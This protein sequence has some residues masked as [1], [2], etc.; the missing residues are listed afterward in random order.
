MV[1]IHRKRIHGYKESGNMYRTT[2]CGL[3][4][5]LAFSESE[6]HHVTLG[7]HRQ[8]QMPDVVDFSP[9]MSY[10]IARRSVSSQ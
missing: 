4:L 10:T 9:P 7:Q 3:R 2:H 8:V 6:K 1:C 5:S